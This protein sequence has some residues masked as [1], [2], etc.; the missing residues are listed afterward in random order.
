M[1]QLFAVI[2]TSTDTIQVR[3]LSYEASNTSLH[4]GVNRIDRVVTD[5]VD[6]WDLLNTTF[7]TKGLDFKTGASDS[8]SIGAND[9]D[10]V[11]NYLGHPSSGGRLLA[12]RNS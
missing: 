5:Q 4:N 12:S 7:S 2:S 8:N 3:M 10:R 6:A 1:Q 9:Y 11:D